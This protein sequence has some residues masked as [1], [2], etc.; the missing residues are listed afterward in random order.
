MSLTAAELP[1]R[2]TTDGVTVETAGNIGAVRCSRLPR[3]RAQWQPVHAE[4]IA[5]LPPDEP[6][7]DDAAM[8]ANRIAR[9]SLAL[10]SHAVSAPTMSTEDALRTFQLSVQ[11]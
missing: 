7:V 10:R 6:I 8:N 2:Q 5:L 1:L 11:P 3:L 4:W 9:E